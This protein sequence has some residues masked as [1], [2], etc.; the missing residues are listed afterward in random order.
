MKDSHKIDMKIGG[1]QVVKKTVNR[2]GEG[3]QEVNVGGK[4]ITMH[5]IQVRHFKS[6]TRI[7]TTGSGT[8]SVYYCL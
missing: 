1:R 3:I 6:H 4:I 7:S 8:L 5:C 2:V